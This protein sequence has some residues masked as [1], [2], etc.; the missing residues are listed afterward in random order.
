MV[1]SETNEIIKELFKFLLQ[2]YQEG[3][4]ESTKGSKFI[5]GSVN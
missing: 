5:F 4:E 2:T 1:G 3:L